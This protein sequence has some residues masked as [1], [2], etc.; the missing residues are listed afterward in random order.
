MTLFGK[1]KDWILA[2]IAGTQML[3]CLAGVV[4]CAWTQDIHGMLLWGIMFEVVA[5]RREKYLETLN[6]E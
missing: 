3:V 4:W 6:A 5:H 1:G 2:P